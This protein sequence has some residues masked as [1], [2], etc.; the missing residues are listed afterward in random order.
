MG[1]Q[2]PEQLWRAFLCL[3]GTRGVNRRILRDSAGSLRVTYRVG[4]LGGRLSRHGRSGQVQ[5]F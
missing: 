4:Y 3:Y 2:F 5:R 1:H